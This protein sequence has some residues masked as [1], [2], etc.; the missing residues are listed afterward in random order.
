MPCS[1][2][3]P[4]PFFRLSVP[5]RDLITMKTQKLNVVFTGVLLEFIV[6]RYSQSCWYFRPSLVN[7]C[8]SNLL[9][10]SPP[11][12]LPPFPK[13]KYCVNRQCV[14]GWGWEVLSCV[15]DH[16]LQEFN[17]LFLTRFGT[18]KLLYHHKQRPRRGGGLRQINPCRKVPLQ[19]NLFR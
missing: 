8:P 9:S 6:W 19:V 13:S 5:T 14:A 7:Y 17:T 16:I 2:M 3:S 15:G 11:P 4:R 12:P 18:Y 1:S 10:G